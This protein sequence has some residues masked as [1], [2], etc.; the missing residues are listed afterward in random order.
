MKKLLNILFLLIKKYCLDKKKVRYKRLV[1]GFTVDGKR[2]KTVNRQPFTEINK[3]ISSLLGL[4]SEGLQIVFLLF[5]MTM[6][7]DAN[8]QMNE[9]DYARELTGVKD[10]WHRIE[11]SD[12]L[13]EK[14]STSLAD[15]RIYGITT[16]NDTVIAPY[17]LDR[18]E[19]VWDTK[20]INFN[21]ILSLIHI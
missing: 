18:K 11:I 8:A 10:Q 3:L 7:F 5:S 17:V 15:I 21:L 13:F 14:M 4:T 1:V 9:Y 19:N 20:N 6:L 16:E 12:D 2:S